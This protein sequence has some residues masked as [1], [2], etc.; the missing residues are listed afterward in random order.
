[1]KDKSSNESKGTG[2]PMSERLRRLAKELIAEMEIGNE[3]FQK[4]I[5]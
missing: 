3:E 1:M 5:R 2:K 4:K